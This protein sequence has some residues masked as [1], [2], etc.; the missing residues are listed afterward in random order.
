MRDERWIMYAREHVIFSTFDYALIA[1]FTGFKSG[2]VLYLTAPRSIQSAVS[3]I[4]RKGTNSS[5]L[6]RVV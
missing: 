6:F 1:A 2:V 5:E 4:Q 3:V